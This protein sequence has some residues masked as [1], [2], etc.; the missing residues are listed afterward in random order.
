MHLTRSMDRDDEGWLLWTAVSADG[1]YEVDLAW[2][3]DS[4]ALLL[5]ASVRRADGSRW[6]EYDVDIVA[7]DE[8]EPLSDE[9]QL[10]RYEY[11]ELEAH[12]KALRARRDRVPT[13]ILERMASLDAT[14][15]SAWEAYDERNM[16]RTGFL[17]NW[18][19][20][21]RA[22]SGTLLFDLLR[23]HDQTIAAYLGD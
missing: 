9:A 17:E 11:A 10:A 15:E 14:H 16:E 12:F 3:D 6:L 23:D 7:P 1:L 18:Q 20:A 13:Q 19:S 5:C 2:D 22:R 8:V 21:L 4:S